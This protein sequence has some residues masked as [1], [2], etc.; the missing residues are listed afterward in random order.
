MVLQ[1]QFLFYTPKEK[2]NHTS[3]LNIFEDRYN[4]SVLAETKDH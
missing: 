1:I 4:T 3:S 2:I